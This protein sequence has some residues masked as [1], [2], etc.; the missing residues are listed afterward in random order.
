MRA[1]KT[2]P[3][4]YVDACNLKEPDRVP[5]H[6]P[7]GDLANILHGVKMHTAMYDIE[8]AMDACREFNKKYSGKLEYYAMQRIRRLS[9]PSDLN[10]AFATQSR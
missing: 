3:Q 1:Y 5:V 10:L 6:L 8:K 9:A 4:R 2:R 7:V